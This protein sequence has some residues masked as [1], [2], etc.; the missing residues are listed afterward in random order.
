MAH[1]VVNTL[2]GGKPQGIAV[3]THMHRILN[4]LGWV[5]T[6][7]PE[8]TRRALEAWLP[9]KEWSTINLLLVGIGQQVQT[10][11]SKIL[12]RCLD[13]S[14][15]IEALRLMHTLGLPLT[16]ADKET[17]ETVLMWAAAQNGQE[18]TM[19][20]LLRVPETEGVPVAS[21]NAK[22]KKGLT[23]ADLATSS[24]MQKMLERAVAIE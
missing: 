14:N 16:H 12:R 15:P 18:A 2:S 21:P 13:T 23:A 1:L 24:K 8:Q 4:Q 6:K 10:E 17:K 11:R 19:R 5:G 22:N 7:T 20:W 3:D 9:Y